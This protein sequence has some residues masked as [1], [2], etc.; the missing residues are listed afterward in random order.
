MKELADT[1]DSPDNALQRAD[2]FLRK[3]L[4]VKPTQNKKYP[5]RDNTG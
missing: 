1:K 3:Q 2:D 4:D 5:P